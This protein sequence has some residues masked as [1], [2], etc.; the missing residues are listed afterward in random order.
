LR[1]GLCDAAIRL[2]TCELKHVFA[3][4]GAP[5]WNSILLFQSP[6]STGFVIKTPKAK[7]ALSDGALSRMF[8]S[9]SLSPLNLNRG[10]IEPTVLASLEGNRTAYKRN[11]E[12]SMRWLGF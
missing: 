10:G 11:T 7:K 4:T 6:A 5:N 1:E 3:G 8:I 9:L 2:A 12:I